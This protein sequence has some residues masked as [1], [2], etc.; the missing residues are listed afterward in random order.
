MDTAILDINLDG[1]MVD[2]VADLLYA[3][4]VPFVLTTGYDRSALL[5]RYAAIKASGE[6]GGHLNCYRRVTAFDGHRQRVWRSIRPISPTVSPGAMARKAPLVM[7]APNGRRLRP[8]L[9]IG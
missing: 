8:A 6:A 1:E 4:G 2:P 9:P 3:R 5:E 7:P